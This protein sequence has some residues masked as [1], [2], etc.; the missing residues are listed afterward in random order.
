MSL[1][2]SQLGE[3]IHDLDVNLHNNTQ[4]DATFVDF[5]RVFDMVSYSYQMAKLV[6]RNLDS[7]VFTGISDFLL[8]ENR[9]Y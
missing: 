5:E 9:S 3:L 6:Q 2:W 1:N 7:G 8:S 4:T